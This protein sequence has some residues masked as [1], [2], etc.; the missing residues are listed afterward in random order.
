M[1][2]SFLAG[3]NLALVALALLVTTTMFAAEPMAQPSANTVVRTA[4][5]DSMKA[6]S[7]WPNP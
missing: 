5:Y 7:R 3:L 1:G 2:R 4:F 6:W